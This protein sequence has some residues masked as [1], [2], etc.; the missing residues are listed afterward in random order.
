MKTFFRLIFL[1]VTSG[2]LEASLPYMLQFKDLSD[3]AKNYHVNLCQNGVNPATHAMGTTLANK[4]FFTV[5]LILK[6]EGSVCIYQLFQI[7]KA[8]TNYFL[9]KAPSPREEQRFRQLHDQ[10]MSIAECVS[11]SLKS[12]CKIRE[13][14]AITAKGT[15]E[16]I[17]NFRLS[18]SEM[19]FLF[20]ITRFNPKTGSNQYIEQILQ[21]ISAGATLQS[22]EL[23]GF[24]TRD[25]C[26]CCFHHMLGFLK[27]ANA[28]Q[29]FFEILLGNLQTKKHVN[30]PA[31]LPVSFYISSLVEL[32]GH[33]YQWSRYS[34]YIPPDNSVPPAE[35]INFK[36]PFAV[37]NTDL[38]CIFLRKNVP[39]DSPFALTQHGKNSEEKTDILSQAN[40]LNKEYLDETFS[41]ALDAPNPV[42]AIEIPDA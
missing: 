3:E 5:Y 35:K 1:I 18:D 15:K 40:T 28:K 9:S 36:T 22:I 8:R 34:S 27:Q 7:A 25:M 38:H 19:R 6:M 13:K 33:E 16:D 32:G 37:P 31:S 30:I 12:Y 21:N 23:H 10:L 2:C 11:T 20:E 26:P 41:T 29:G 4:N 17:R 14:E 42:G 39:G 24:T